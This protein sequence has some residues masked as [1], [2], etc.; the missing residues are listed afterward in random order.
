MP[1]FH[2]FDLYL[3]C[4]MGLIEVS[5]ALRSRRW[6]TM[7]V[8]AVAFTAYHLS[9]SKRKLVEKNLQICFGDTLDPPTRTRITQQVFVAYWRETFD[10][11]LTDARQSLPTV[12]IEGL[13]H[14][15]SAVARGKG[16][17]LWE[18]NSFGPRLLVK[19]VLQR[20]GFP[21][22]QIHALDHVGGIGMGR[23]E[24]SHLMQRVILPYFDRH[25]REVVADI[26][27]LDE[28]EGLGFTRRLHQQLEQNAIV[29]S[30]IEGRVGQK[31]IDLAFLG[32]T[33]A[34]ATGMVSLAKLSGAPLLPIYCAFSDDGTYVL[35][36][37]PPIEFPCEL[38]RQELAQWV[39]TK[40]VSELESRVR[41]HP[42][43]FRTW[44]SLH[45]ER[46]I[47]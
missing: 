11:V 27:Y 4:V 5:S 6:R 39:L 33:R 3:L 40:Q 36:I 41:K 7:L 34:F 43:W 45:Q 29:C 47:P 17:I 24:Q 1:S 2:W 31:H 35:E 12:R 38:A 26:I 10:W 16:A 30:A 20:N 32:Q 46:P 9:Q 15:R 19:I 21:V 13:H 22:C 44:D 8:S 37:L 42:E 25:E 28:K 18:S 23:K 14:L